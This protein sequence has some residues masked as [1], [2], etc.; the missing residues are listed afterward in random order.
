MMNGGFGLVLV[1]DFEFGLVIII[2][3]LGFF[4]V[5]VGRFFFVILE[6]GGCIGSWLVLDL[7]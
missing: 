5:F 7:W 1:D 3:F 4:I 2:I 6:I